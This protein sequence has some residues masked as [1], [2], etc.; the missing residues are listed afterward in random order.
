MWL[1]LL[2]V[3]LC[4][5]LQARISA[6]REDWHR[7]MVQSTQAEI[8]RALSSARGAWVANHEDESDERAT[9]L[10]KSLRE[11]LKAQFEDEKRQLVDD[12]F[13]E[14]EEKFN[15]EKR[16]LQEQ[17]TR[18]KVSLYSVYCKDITLQ[19]ETVYI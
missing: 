7:E 16:E 3:K 13:K 15:T 5:F 1:F 19:K 11:R 14:T 12:T 17:L 2:N 8:D 4:V 18:M 6:A 10:E 9:Q